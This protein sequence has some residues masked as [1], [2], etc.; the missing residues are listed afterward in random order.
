[1]KSLEEQLEDVEVERSS[2]TK[3][4]RQLEQQLFDLKSQNVGK[5]QEK[6]LRKDIK[7]LIF[8][9]LEKKHKKLNHNF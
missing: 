2:I 5:E 6:A 9:K 7:R 1:M 3:Q 8:F 4:K